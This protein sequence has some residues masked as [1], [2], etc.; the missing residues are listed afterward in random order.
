MIA[1]CVAISVDWVLFAMVLFL[2]L[3]VTVQSDTQIQNNPEY[4][5]LLY[6]AIQAVSIRE[7]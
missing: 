1:F 6:L 3:F 2:L 7:Y 4:F 5:H